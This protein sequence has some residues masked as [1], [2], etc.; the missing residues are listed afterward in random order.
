MVK[1]KL[2]ELRK[3]T[4]DYN[5]LY[6]LMKE[7]KKELD[8]LSKTLETNWTGN[9]QEAFLLSFS[10]FLSGTYA[11]TMEKTRKING[12]LKAVSSM[13]NEYLNRAD[14]FTDVLES[15]EAGT[16]NGVRSKGGTLYLDDESIASLGTLVTEITT[17]QMPDQSASLENFH[18]SVNSG[19]SIGSD[20]RYSNIDLETDYW[21]IKAQLE[22]QKDSIE[23]FGT[24]VNKYKSG[25]ETLDSAV[26]RDFAKYIDAEGNKASRKMYKPVK[27]DVELDTSQIY[28]LLHTPADA[29]TDEEYKALIY[30]FDK[31][32]AAGDMDAVEQIIKSGYEYVA[33][34]AM[35]TY[36]GMV[37]DPYHFTLT[38]AFNEMVSRY[39]KEMQDLVASGEIDLYSM[40]SDD[41]G[42]MY[43]E[44]TQN[45]IKR[46]ESLAILQ[47]VKIYA[48]DIY[49]YG[50]YGDPSC[51]KIL[52]EIPKP[53]TGQGNG[54]DY[55]VIIGGFKHPLSMEEVEQYIAGILEEEDYTQ[56][57]IYGWDQEHTNDILDEI[58][59]NAESDIKDP[60]KAV[61]DYLSD[62]LLSTLLGAAAGATGVGNIVTA[63]Q[64]L[65]G[66]L[67]AY[68]DTAKQNGKEQAT[69]SNANL[70]KLMNALGIR[71]SFSVEAGGKIKF[72][73]L[74]IDSREAKAR[75]SWFFHKKG[76]EGKN[77]EN[78]VNEFSEKDFSDAKGRYNYLDNPEYLKGYDKI[79]GL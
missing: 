46:L 8:T 5:N 6:K 59:K 35:T 23:E 78:F 56:I 33:E 43:N 50:E 79:L 53:T 77:F 60:N 70:L 38:G 26:T 28:Y 55:K 65:E 13:A 71:S 7:K 58:A 12:I 19:L 36:G 75:I 20:L 10:T 34:D 4:N 30:T 68:K 44:A 15:G 14:G 2:G 63:V 37:I 18:N 39:E 32:M 21:A 61:Q 24:S 67:Q 22:K 1:L 54:N 29:L 41:N 76:N 66:A 64:T 25:I 45:F 51:D 11:D 52:V 47:D 69:I 17:L 42:I 9:D 3:A 48:S 74:E 73:Y 16:Y 27:P 49:L 62:T 40:L 72:N 57:S 31:K